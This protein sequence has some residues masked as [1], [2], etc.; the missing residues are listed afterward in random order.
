MNTGIIVAGGNSVRFGQDKQLFEIKKIPVLLRTILAFDCST[1]ID[2]V[3][4]VTKT[5]NFDTLSELISE[6]GITK[7]VKMVAGGDT[8]QKSVM[9]GLLA[10]EGSEIVAIH[11][12]ARPFVSASDIDALVK[13]AC[14]CGAVAPAVSIPDTV[15][16]VQGDKLLSVAD[17]DKLRLIQTPQVFK[18]EKIFLAHKNAEEDGFL[19]TDDCSLIRHSGG[20][21]VITEG[22]PHNIKITSFEDVERAEFICERLGEI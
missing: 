2:R 10:S 17:R 5:E 21:V 9:N 13:K 3:V 16:E 15:I 18:Y 8:R 6:Y 1:L 14:E 19:G 7:P 11:D 12:G 22:N 4:V 20:E